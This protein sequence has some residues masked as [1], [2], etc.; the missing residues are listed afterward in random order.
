MAKCTWLRP[1]WYS[2]PGV[3][4]R[5]P[6]VQVRPWQCCRCEPLAAV[7]PEGPRVSTN[8][9]LTQISGYMGLPEL[10]SRRRDPD[11]EQP[12]NH[13]DDADDRRHIN[14]QHHHHNKNKKKNNRST[15]NV[16]DLHPSF[17]LGQATP[18]IR[19]YS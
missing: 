3:G 4:A 1:S 5:S 6:P 10:V 18:Q 13:D 17:R 9:T 16:L 7:A 8:P 2:T 15:Q 12:V 11:L 14:H 19:K